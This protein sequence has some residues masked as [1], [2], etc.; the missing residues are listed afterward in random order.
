MGVAFMLNT[1]DFCAN[2]KLAAK[3]TGG[4]APQKKPKKDSRY[5]AK[6]S[7]LNSSQARA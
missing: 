4:K 1:C 2:P 7:R 5:L 6:Y 3:S